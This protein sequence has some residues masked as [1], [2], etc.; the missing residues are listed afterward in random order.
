M[1]SSSNDET[2]QNPA[3]HEMNFSAVGDERIF[4]AT[5]AITWVLASISS[6]NSVAADQMK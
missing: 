1:I 6:Y 5:T 3:G 2:S 4:P